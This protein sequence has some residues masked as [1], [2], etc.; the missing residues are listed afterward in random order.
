MADETE[1]IINS[2]P[3]PEW[4]RLT[5]S[6]LLGAGTVGAAALGII[7]KVVPGIMHAVTIVKKLL[8]IITAVKPILNDPYIR[9]AYG[10]D[11]AA[12]NTIIDEIEAFCIDV[13][14]KKSGDFLEKYKIK[15]LNQQKL[16]DTLQEVK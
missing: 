4:L 14:V 1:S 10:S 8:K 6:V 16:F 9:E 5:F 11:I 13:G 2:L 3:F 15:A 12:V 7:S